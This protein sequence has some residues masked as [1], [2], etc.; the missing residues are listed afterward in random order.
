M[1]ICFIVMLITGVSPAMAWLFKQTV[2]SVSSAMVPQGALDFS[3]VLLDAK[4]RKAMLKRVIGLP[5]TEAN[6]KGS[7]LHSKYCN[8]VYNEL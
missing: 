6:P 4:N 8:P 3:A 1:M 2:G 5:V 7:G